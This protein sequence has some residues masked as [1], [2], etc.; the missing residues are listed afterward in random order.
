MGMGEAEARD[1]T[2]SCSASFAIG[3]ATPAGGRLAGATYRFS[4]QGT[5]GY[6]APN[7]ARERALANINECLDAAW[8]HRL[9]TSQPNACRESNEVYS[10]PF[11]GLHFSVTQAVCLA[12]RGHDQILVDL[13]VTYSG[14]TGCVPA[15]NNWM[16]LITRAYT[17][18]CPDYDAGPLH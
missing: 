14:D 17:I 2:R 12:N 9:G 6:Y 1:Y 13:S 3:A 4:G 8:A 16:R 11:T 10:Y 18:N 15:H 5:V 7:T